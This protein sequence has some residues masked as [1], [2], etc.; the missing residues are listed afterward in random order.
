MT[1]NVA[2][3]RETGVVVWLQAGVATLAERVGHS[4]RRPLLRDEDTSTRL[5]SLLD[6]RS[7]AYRDAA[8]GTIATDG[9]ELATV[10]TRIEELWNAY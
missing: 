5:Q 6:E 4:S 3:M 10:V 1:A 8:H 7:D 2:L 9:L